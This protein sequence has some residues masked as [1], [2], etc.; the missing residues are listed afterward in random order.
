MASRA[1]GTAW[2]CIYPLTWLKTSGPWKSVPSMAGKTK[3]LED[4]RQGEILHLPGRPSA[5]LQMTYISDCN[6]NSTPPKLY[7]W[8]N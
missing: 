8:Q 3:H 4:A 5:T 1:D 6:D 2:S 7:G